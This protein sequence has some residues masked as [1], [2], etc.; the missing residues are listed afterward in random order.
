M[1]ETT[2]Q[3]IQQFAERAEMA[4]SQAIEL[5]VTGVRL[6]AAFDII[7]TIMVLATTFVSSKK[8]FDYAEEHEPSR[9]HSMEDSLFSAATVGAITVLFSIML[10]VTLADMALNVVIPEYAIMKDLLA[11]AQ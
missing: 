3:V 1:D 6:E 9:R 8:A 10:Y 7:A 4:A 2:Q 5:Y 11:A